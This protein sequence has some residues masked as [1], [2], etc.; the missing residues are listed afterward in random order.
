[1]NK[2]VATDYNDFVSP[3]DEI[4]LDK[5]G[6]KI[7]GL[8][9]SSGQMYIEDFRKLRDNAVAYNTHGHGLYGGPRTT[10]PLPIP[11]KPVLSE[12]IDFANA[13]VQAVEEEIEKQKES[14][15]EEEERIKSEDTEKAHV[16]LLTSV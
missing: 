5:I 4:W 1:M 9:Y 16:T 15:A 6:S 13:L 8:K 7:R 10:C 2:T 11:L 3:T 14:I 12:I